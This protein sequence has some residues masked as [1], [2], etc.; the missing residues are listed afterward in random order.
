MP[1]SKYSEEQ[2]LAPLRTLLRSRLSAEQAAEVGGLSAT[3]CRDR[4]LA[5]GPLDAA[6]VK[7]VNQAEAEHWRRWWVLVLLWLWVIGSA[8]SAVAG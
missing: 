2:Q 4:L 3:Q 7:R 5:L 1:A 6:W 8:S